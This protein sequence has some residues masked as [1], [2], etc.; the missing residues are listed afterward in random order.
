MTPDELERLLEAHP[1]FRKAD[2]KPRDQ[3]DITFISRPSVE[4]QPA[5]D[6]TA[7]V[8]RV[9]GPTPNGGAYMIVAQYPSGGETHVEIT[10]FGENDEPIFRTYGRA[11]PR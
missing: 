1:R 6:E 4:A 11:R 5:D 9:E 8:K 7:S 3:V 2:P 10:E